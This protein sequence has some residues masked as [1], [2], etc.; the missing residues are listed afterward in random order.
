M[1]VSVPAFIEGSGEPDGQCLRRIQ[2]ALSAPLLHWHRAS[3]RRDLPL[4]GRPL[5]LPPWKFSLHNYLISSLLKQH[6]ESE[7]LPR[8]EAGKPA[9]VSKC[10]FCSLHNFHSER[11]P[12]TPKWAKKKR[13][14]CKRYGTAHS[15]FSDCFLIPR[16]NHNCTLPCYCDWKAG[17]LSFFCFKS[18][19][20]ADIWLTF[21]WSRELMGL[22]RHPYYCPCLCSK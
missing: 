16:R 13:S 17:A 20:Q 2:M 4:S 15:P 7:H 6:F 11:M 22:Y 18:A 10:P 21:L 9:F 3:A 5:P 12:Y 19:L 8:V 14:S 1:S